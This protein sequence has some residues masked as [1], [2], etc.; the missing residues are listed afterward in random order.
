MTQ[1][2][3]EGLAELAVLCDLRSLLKAEKGETNLRLA[4]FSP[5]PQSRAP[6]LER[7]PLTFRVNLLPLLNLTTMETPSQVDPEVCPLGDSKAN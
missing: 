7:M 1:P 6:A 2:C 5:F 4:F 3:G